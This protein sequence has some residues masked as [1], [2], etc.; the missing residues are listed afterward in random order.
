MNVLSASK[1][2]AITVDAVRPVVDLVSTNHLCWRIGLPF[3]ENEHY[4]Q[5]F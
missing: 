3:I 4:I 2:G 5:I 1:A